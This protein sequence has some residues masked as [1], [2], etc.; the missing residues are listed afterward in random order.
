MVPVELLGIVILLLG[1]ALP[2]F[3]IRAGHSTM[4]PLVVIWVAQTV[5]VG[6]ALLDITGEMPMPR[7]VTWFVLGASLLGILAGWL[8]AMMMTRSTVPREPATILSRKRLLFAFAILSILY[9]LS[10]AQGVLRQGG[11]PLLAQKPDTARAMFMIGQMQNIF[12]GAGIPMFIIGI[13]LFR[14]SPERWIRLLV[15]LAMGGLMC[16]YLLIGS[17]FMTLIWLSMAICYWDLGVRKLPIMKLASLILGFL[18]L[19]A[20][21]GYFR[22]GQMLAKASGSSKL[23]EVGVLVALNSIYSYIAN[24]YWNLDNALHLWSLGVLK[25]PTW[26][27]SMNE[28]VLWTLGLLPQ[29]QT[30]Y[31]FSN[32]L[33]HDIMLYSGLN[34]TCYHWPLFKDALLF[35]PVAGSFAMGWL[36]TFVH[37]R[38][39]HKDDVAGIIMYG[40]LAYLVLGSFNILPT[41]FP[42][43]IW[44]LVLLLGTLYVASVPRRDMIH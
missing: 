33:N 4:S 21:V 39:C 9:F 11:F 34:A 38:R 23:V 14:T 16:T 6:I 2:I 30:A 37:N 3:L 12:F 24:G 29:M 17:R 27:L 25:L 5:P 19:F 32:A 13:H 1:F 40:F 26:G 8:V 22:Y 10:I 36:L 41:V 20:L 28:G 18:F 43:P 35:G 15:A 44:G 7:L 31:G 42:T